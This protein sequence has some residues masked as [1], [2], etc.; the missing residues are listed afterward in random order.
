MRYIFLFFLR[1]DF[2]FAFAHQASTFKYWPDQRLSCPHFENDFDSSKAS[3]IS[4]TI[5]AESNKADFC[6]GR[7]QIGGTKLMHKSK[8]WMKPGFR[9]DY[10]ISHEHLAHVSIEML[11]QTLTRLS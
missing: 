2:A 7:I 4:I 6:S 8:S 11:Y 9:N 3:Q 5:F 10:V 1:I